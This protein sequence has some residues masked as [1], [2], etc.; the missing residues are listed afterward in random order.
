[1]LDF[2]ADIGIIGALAD[3]VEGIIRLLEGHRT[4]SFSGVSFHLGEL[5][6]KKVVVARCGVGKVFAALCA[7]AMVLRY[8]PNLLVNTGVGGALADGLTPGDIV[9]ADALVQHDMDTSPLGDPKGLISGI[10]VI[11]FPTDRRA[12][13]ILTAVAELHSLKFR[14]GTVA[15]GDKFVCDK[16][17]KEQIYSDFSAVACEMEGGAIAQVAYVNGT[18]CAVIR[19]ISDSADGSASM[20]YMEFLPLAV[21]SSLLLTLELVRLY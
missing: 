21:R 3:E 14:V 20:D 16:T 10:N 12:M 17:D 9:L 5:Y 8:S 18:P 1:M 11:S 2:K 7:E 19:A 15:T 6:G 4:E 13:N